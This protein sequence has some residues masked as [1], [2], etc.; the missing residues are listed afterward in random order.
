MKGS[1]MLRTMAVKISI[2]TYPIACACLAAGFATTPLEQVLDHYLVINELEAKRFKSE[3]ERPILVIGNSW[4]SEKIFKENY[5]F[6]DEEMID[7]FTE[8]VKI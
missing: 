1:I 3:G 5:K 4:M 7:T 2:K 6:K 8:V